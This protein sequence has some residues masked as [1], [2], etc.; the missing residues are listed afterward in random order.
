MLG[1]TGTSRGK[2]TTARLRFLRVPTEHFGGVDR[3]RGVSIARG[4]LDADMGRATSEGRPGANGGEGQ[5]KAPRSS[6][7]AAPIGER[8][9]HRRPRAQARAQEN[10]GGLKAVAVGAG[11]LPRTPQPYCQPR[12]RLCDRTVPTLPSGGQTSGRSKGAGR[13]RL[14]QRLCIEMSLAGLLRFPPAGRSRRATGGHGRSLVPVGYLTGCETKAHRSC[15]AGFEV[16]SCRQI[17]CKSRIWSASDGYEEV[18]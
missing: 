15:Q 2:A 1:S 16:F 13:R 6:S 8:G 18:I 10:R 12:Q 3:R 17:N 14:E 11:S 7:A 4:T 9:R 5:L